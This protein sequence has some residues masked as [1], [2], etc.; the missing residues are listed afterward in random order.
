MFAERS[1]RALVAIG[2]L[3][4]LPLLTAGFGARPGG[5]AHPP[6]TRLAGG[7][8]PVRGLATVALEA[9]ATAVARAV[10]ALRG[11]AGRRGVFTVPTRIDNRLF[12]MVPGTEFV[13]R[14]RIVEGGVSRPHSVTF[15]VTDLTKMVDGVRTVVAWDRDFLKGRLQEQELA[16]FAQDEQGNVWNF[17]EY[18]EEYENGKF[19][20]APSTWIRGGRHSYGGI[21][22][23]ARPRAGD[24]YVEGLVPAIEFDDLSR[25]THTGQRTCVPAGCYRRV[26]VVDESSP[27][28]PASGHQ[29]KYYARGTGLVRVGARGGDTQEFLGLVAVER[30]G[31]AAMTKVRAAVLSM[32]RRAYRISKVYRA[33]GPA[34]RCHG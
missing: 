13:Y 20:G 18:P 10:H 17:G 11:Q 30:L 4:V 5:A 21:H 16:F 34:V 1:V 14:G 9:K 8:T 29:I 33:T 24:R 26:L 3:G 32:D 19:T 22:M 2:A 27:N 28:D 25:V 7:T 23:L 15:T 12:P 6:G 31:A